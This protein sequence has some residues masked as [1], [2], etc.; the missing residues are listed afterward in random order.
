VQVQESQYTM[1]PVADEEWNEVL[2]LIARKG[3]TIS[4]IKVSIC[5]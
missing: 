2:L 5:F 3:R 4:R 1:E